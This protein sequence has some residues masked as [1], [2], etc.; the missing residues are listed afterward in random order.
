[1]A[2]HNDI[3]E[4]GELLAK[5]FLIN[6]GY[7]ILAENYRYE[8]AEIDL[9]AEKDHCIVFVEVKTR[10]SLFDLPEN[11]VTRKK[12][13]LMS[14]AAEN[15]LYEFKIEASIR[16]DIISIVITDSIPHFTHI[17]DAFFEIEG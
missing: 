17:E 8:K 1:M 6:K 16:F 14:L 5:G 12:M 2:K 9:I 4:I 3:G 15:Y 11:A 7:K 13:K 10:T